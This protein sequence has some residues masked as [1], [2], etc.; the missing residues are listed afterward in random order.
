[1]FKPLANEP[2]PRQG[3][4]Q[5]GLRHDLGE[6]L[7]EPIHMTQGPLILH[8]PPHFAPLRT[9]ELLARLV[10]LL[11][12]L[13]TAQEM[14]IGVKP[15]QRRL[16]LLHRLFRLHRFIEKPLRLAPGPPRSTRHP[17]G[18]MTATLIL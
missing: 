5:L 8:Q 11:L 14:A 17:S 16:D 9:A 3:L 13:T 7:P 2:Q 4:T 15:Q 6:V 1:M 10:E 18:I 12:S